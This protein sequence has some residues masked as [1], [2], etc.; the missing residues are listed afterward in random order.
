MSRIERYEEAVNFVSNFNDIFYQTI[1]HN[2][3]SHI[4]D[5]FLKDLFNKNSSKTVDKA[6][7]LIERFGKTANPANFTAQA[8]A[9]N[10]QPTTFSLIFSIALHVSSK[11][12]ENFMAYFFLKFGNLGD[13]VSDDMDSTSEDDPAAVEFHRQLDE[14][15]KKLSNP[16][17]DTPPILPDVEMTPVDQSVTPKNSQKKDK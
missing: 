9:T 11:S 7:L 1:S 10:I 14:L 13:D 17:V 6:Q 3:G 2:L 16:V 15:R 8:Q 12:W 4:E 5:G